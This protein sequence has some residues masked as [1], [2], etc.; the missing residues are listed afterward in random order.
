MRP[1]DLGAYR[2][3]SD[4]RLHPDGT[5]VALVVTQI[6]VEGDHYH[7][8]IWLW[9]GNEARALTE[10]FVDVKPRWSP[11]G[12]TLVFLRAPWDKPT[13]F[14]VMTFSGGD[15]AELAV[16]EPGAKEAEWS[17]DGK[18]LAVVASVWT[19]EYAGLEPDERDRRPARLS[20]ATWQWDNQAPKH[21]RR[22]RLFVV[23]AATGFAELA[24][25]DDF[26]VA[27]VTWSPTGDRIAF[28]SA[29]HETRFIG[30]GNQPWEIGVSGGE[31]QPL[32]D[33]GSW[34]LVRYDGDGVVHLVGAADPWAYPDIGRVYKRESDGSLTDL[35]GHLDRDPNPFSPTLAPKGPQFTSRGVMVPLEDS[36]RLGVH[37]LDGE[38][39]IG[40]D[41]LVTGFD[42][43][44]DGAIMAF[45]ATTVTNPGELLWWD[46]DGE[47]QLTDFNSGFSSATIEPTPFTVQSDGVE[48]QA[49]AYLPPGEAPAPM[50]LNI[51][52]GP[53]TQYGYGFFDEFQVYAAAGYGVVA[54]NPRGASGR[55][56]EFSRSIVGRWTD[57]EP[58]DIADL[59]AV[60]DAALERFPRLDADR[61][62]VMGGS[63][64]GFATLRLTAADT[65]FKSAVAERALTSFQSFTGTSDIGP[66]FGEMY[67]EA[68]MPGGEAVLQQASPMNYAHLIETPTLVVHSEN[69]WRCPLEQGLQLLTM[70]QMQGVPS[71]MIRFPGEGHELSRLGRPRHRVERFEAILDWHARYLG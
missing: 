57:H 16:F 64:G 9:D 50:L 2:V 45:V 35:S 15:V 39:L 33:I 58:P 27:E 66:F 13:E 43:A 52:G 36:G 70:L 23:D 54:A 24:T 63:Y 1:S 19:D 8:Q 62:G 48:I 11:D 3:P 55:G 29:R 65:R 7:R 31:V 53:N 40:G 12:S 4:P 18:S 30:P 41:R 67:L 44:A 17:P 25:D 20:R 51:H 68:A 6:D 32:A 46:G 22:S 21:D 60:T 26:D 56:K 38:Q 69:D 5:Q 42:A 47:R 37:T 61:M 59:K 14:N 34:D 10:G 49:W 71:E 28:I